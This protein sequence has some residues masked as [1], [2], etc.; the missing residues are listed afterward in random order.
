EFNVFLEAL[1]KSGNDVWLRAVII[2]TINDYTD[3]IRELWDL[4]KKIPRVKKFELLPYHTLGVN[5]YKE[6]GLKYP[7]EGVPPMNRRHVE[8][9]QDVINKALMVE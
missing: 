4:A 6:L 1:K 7:L 8:K 3:Y 2:P 9:W 5:K